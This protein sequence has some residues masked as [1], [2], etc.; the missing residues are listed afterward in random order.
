MTH[1]GDRSRPLDRATTRRGFGQMI[2]GLALAPVLMPV[3]MAV[4]GPAR[5]ASD[6][7]PPV[8]PESLDPATLA[9]RLKT[10]DFLLVNVHVPY[11]GEIAGTDAFVPFDRID[12]NL[13]QFPADRAAPVVVYCRSGRMSAV[14]ARRLSEL[15]FSRVSDLAGGMNA[16][17]DAGFALVRQ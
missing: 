6:G 16:W 12:A 14:A 5:A 2:S 10:K 8:P 15:G 17:K 1:P 3:L 11:D 13:A 4:S 7:N 9:A